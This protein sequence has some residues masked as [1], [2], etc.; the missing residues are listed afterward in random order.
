MLPIFLFWDDIETFLVWFCELFFTDLH[1]I[2]RQESESQSEGGSQRE[3]D[4]ARAQ[5][6][7]TQAS[8]YN[9][10]P[11]LGLSLSL[12]HKRQPRKLAAELYTE[13]LIVLAI[14]L[15]EDGAKQ[16]HKLRMLND[17]LQLNG[18]H[19]G[20]DVESH[21]SLGLQGPSFCTCAWWP[22]TLE[23]P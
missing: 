20:P 6:F 23:A 3:G 19:L 21:A 9:R 12:Q 11:Q 15:S 8:M 18:C 16:G 1:G 17:T 10:A 5:F 7:Q 4:L 13:S 14:E 22:A 2:Y